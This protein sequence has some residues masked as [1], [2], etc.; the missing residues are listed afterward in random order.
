MDLSLFH[1]KDIFPRFVTDKLTRV[2]VDYKEK[3]NSN[4]DANQNGSF[5]R[6][7][8]VVLLLNYKS[9]QDKP[10]Y[11]FQ[12]IKRSGKVSQAGDIS[13]PGG[14]LHPRLDHIL[15]HFL[16][17]GIISMPGE[18][19]R[20]TQSKDKET[21]YLIRLF[22]TTALREAWE[23]VGLNPF[24]VLFLGALPSYSLTLFARTI[25]PLACITPKHFKYK[26]NS[27]VEKVL[28]I[29]LSFFFDS[30]N[31]AI[32]NIKTSPKN[33]SASM[34]YNC[35]VIPD[36]QGGEDILWGATL[37]IIDNFLRIVSDD[38]LPA[39]AT[40]RIITKV[41]TTNYMSSKS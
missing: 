12:L 32:L 29:P 11:V 27:E 4:N 6:Q 17:L 23:E 34:K 2:V 39:F 3:Y 30:A 10:E 9:N 36:G 22:L 20:L 13:C 24:N 15:S 31:Y 14:M 38:N 37:K 18:K 41:L 26:L 33:D 25:F 21:N 16:K 7:A 5:H 19:V 1:Q 40:S 28:E 8:G 35:I